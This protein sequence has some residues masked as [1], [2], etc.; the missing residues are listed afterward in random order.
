MNASP[1]SRYGLFV[2][3]AAVLVAAWFTWTLRSQRAPQVLVSS[4]NRDSN[5]QERQRRQRAVAL[6]FRA[7]H[8]DNNLTYSAVSDTMAMYGGRTM[9]AVANV[10]RAPQSLSIEYTDGPQKGLRSGFNGRWFWRQ[11]PGAQL[12]A[13]AAMKINAA[14]IMARRFA[15]MLENYDVEWKERGE[16]EGHAVEIV[17]VMPFH[18]AP[19]AQGPR[20]RIAIDTETGLSLRVETF[21]HRKQLIMRTTLSKVDYAPQ[22]TP[23]APARIIEVSRRKDWMIQD[24]GHDTATVVKLTGLHPPK[25]AYLP[26]GFQFDTV[27][28][29][30]CSD[31]KTPFQAALARYTDGVNT[32]TIFVLKPGTAADLANCDPKSA[33]SEDAPQTPLAQPVVAETGALVPPPGGK[34]QACDF[35]PGTLVTRNT[36]QGRLIAVGDLP[37]AEL[38]R[39]IDGASIDGDAIVQPENVKPN[40]A[41]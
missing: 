8:A 38:Q 36:P 23:I 33:T 5:L 32:L 28:V 41:R 40:P 3:S 14:D 26:Q 27:G 13:Y 34:G 25:P 31:A 11:N 30:H 15:L 12:E 24:L 20:K 19:G 18:P 4:I 10:T 22:V 6:L 35:G 21:D 29:H 2:A 39:V 1:F 37:A 17:E 7:F 16:I 9:E